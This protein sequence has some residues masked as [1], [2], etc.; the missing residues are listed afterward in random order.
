MN[1][2]AHTPASG[3]RRVLACVSGMSPAVVTETL[4]V[5]VTQHDFIP[6]EIHVITTGQ[7]RDKV[8][9]NLLA[10]PDGHFHR[11]MREYLPQGRIRFDAGTIHVIGAD[12]AGAGGLGD[13]QTDAENRLAADTLYRVLREI[14]NVPGTVLHASVAG[15]RK[16]MSFYMGHAF[17]LVAEPAD[18]LSH[19]LVNEPF[20]GTV[21]EFHYPPKTPRMMKIRKGGAEAGEISSDKA[22][23]QLAE[24]S[25]LKLGAMLGTL[26]PKA[27]TSFDFAVRIAQ[28]T[29]TPPPVRVVWDETAERGCVE[30]LGERIDLPPQQFL[31]LALHA[32]ARRHEAELP[33]GS[34]LLIE[35]LPATL[36]RRLSRSDGEL[37]TTSFKSARSRL[38]STLREHIGPAAEW[39]TIEP[40]DDKKRKGEERPHTL[41]L[42]ADCLTLV[43]LHEWW[44]PLRQHLQ[45]R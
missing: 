24:L 9:Q 36:L 40:V 5:L 35:D 19:V 27:Q 39:L 20:D 33:A 11:F 1:T 45:S 10:E 15:G 38:V 26:P 16:S 23:L 18:R 42:P 22:E 12:A 31:V 4:H 28:A 17:S 3:P 14:K 29:L 30:T 2:P 44:P 7:G 21:P 41:R 8:L 32:M 37:R 43:S 13:I 25:V 34:A 6:D